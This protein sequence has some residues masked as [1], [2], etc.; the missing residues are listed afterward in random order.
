VNDDR[1]LG[2]TDQNYSCLNRQTYVGRYRA[3]H[4][5]VLGARFEIFTAVKIQVEMF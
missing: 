4:K 2:P 5:I 1:L 3:L